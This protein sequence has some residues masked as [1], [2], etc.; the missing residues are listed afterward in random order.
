[1]LNN[2]SKLLRWILGI[3]AFSLSIIVLICSTLFW[4]YGTNTQHT[5]RKSIWWTERGRNLIP[6]QAT[7]ITLQQ[8][9]LDHYATYTIKEGDL[10]AFL[11]E[12]F[13]RDGDEIDSLSDRRP[14]SASQ[15]G[16][17]IGRLGWVVTKEVV[18]Y[19]YAAPNGGMHRYYH[20]PVSGS[21]Y[22]ESAYW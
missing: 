8:D 22:Q 16:A 9:F 14:V 19:D 7:G 15:V 3:C 20:N 17:S 4:I 1:M 5:T 11:D 10:N 13:S 18:V 21:T 6:P 12:H 2:G